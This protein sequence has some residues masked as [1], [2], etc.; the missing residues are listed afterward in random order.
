MATSFAFDNTFAAQMDGFFL[1]AEAAAFPSPELVVLNEPL[2][3]SLGLDVGA[4]N[5]DAAST[6]SGQSVPEGAEPIAQFYAGHQFGGFS[7]QLGDGRALLLGELLDRE[8][9]RF[10]LQ[11][12]GSGPTEFSRGGDGKASLGPMLREYVI[13]EAMHALGIPTTRSLAVVTTGEAVFRDRPLPGAVL[14]RV[15]ASHLRVGTFEYFASRQDV[16]NTRKLADYTIERHYPHLADT[17]KPYVGLLNAVVDAQA[18][19]IAQWMLVG[20]IHGVMN[21]DN[22]TLS[23][24]T[25]DYG[26]CAFMDSFDPRTVYS[27]IDHKGR[28]AYGNQ[29]GIG[30]WNIARFAETLLPLLDEDADVSME[31]ARKSLQ[32][33]A[34]RYQS[35]W[36]RGMRAKL[37]IVEADDEDESLASALTKLLEG[38]R[39]DYTKAMRGLS[40]VA[41]GSDDGFSDVEGF[42]AWAARW[43]VRLDREP[44]GREGAAERM[45]AVNPAYI[46]RND[47]VEAALDSA[48]EGDLAPMR[49]LLDAVTRPF[50][51]RA[52]MERYAEPASETFDECFKTF[53]GT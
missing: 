2:A 16:A 32:A 20:F 19:L 29:P 3:T 40:D 42:D 10:D 41:R 15:A 24:E 44:G 30:Q 52:G 38:A 21:T 11:L 25:I 31:H 18:D 36:T 9:R 1:P 46:P 28:Y 35:A 6:F 48:V 39:L 26:P 47:L 8:G 22:V 45:D 49:R 14:A 4:L 12:K 34:L 43:L 23:G 37:G 51:P 27:S 33:F 53:C 50:H 17:P 5:R 7:P 13:S